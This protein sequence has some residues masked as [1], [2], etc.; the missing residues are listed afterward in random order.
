MNGLTA[1]LMVFTSGFIVMVL[2]IVGARFLGRDFGG[3]FYVWVSQ[4]GVI[5]IALAAGSYLGG[6]W[7]DRAQRL[8]PIGVCLLVAGLFTALQ[9]ELAPPLIV[10]IVARHPADAPIPMVWQKLD[11]VLGSAVV[12]LLPALALATLPPYLIRWS[13]GSLGRLGRSSAAIVASNTLG[14]IAGVFVTGYV[15]LDVMRISSIFRLMGALIALLA[16]CCLCADRRG[17]RAVRNLA[18]M[19]HEL[20]TAAEPNTPEGAPMRAGTLPAAAG[21]PTGCP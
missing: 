14:G 2:E 18:R 12:F 13:T 9:P 3:S 1:R 10:S 16:V 8:R 7:A 11:P 15:L 21:A 19:C 17:P 6:A 4:I 20:V 5:L